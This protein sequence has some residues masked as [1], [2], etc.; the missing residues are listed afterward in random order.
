MSQPSLTQLGA[1]IRVLR[2]QRGLSIEAL[3]AEAE[4]HTV[5]VSRI[6]GGK[7][8]PTWIALVSLATAIDVD[9]LELVRLA[10]EQPRS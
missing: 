1:A 8:N 5:S 3:A 10:G 7:Q 6:E 9:V 2:E 4:L